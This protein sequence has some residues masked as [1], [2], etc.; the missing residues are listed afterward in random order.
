MN[1]DDRDTQGIHLIAP[2]VNEEQQNADLIKACLHVREEN[3]VGIL[4][5][6]IDQVFL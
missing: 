6:H 5:D 4:E 2:S 3:R 1:I